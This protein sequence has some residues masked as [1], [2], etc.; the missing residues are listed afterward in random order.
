MGLDPFYTAMVEYVETN[1]DV[2]L[3]AVDSLVDEL[4][5]YR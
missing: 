4:L 2:L 5:M 3:S 1:A